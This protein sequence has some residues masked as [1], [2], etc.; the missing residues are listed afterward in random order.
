MDTLLVKIS[1]YFEQKSVQYGV[2]LETI[3]VEGRENTSA[4]DVAK[5]LSARKGTSLFDYDVHLLREK[6][7]DLPW[8]R[9]AI[10]Q[11]RFPSTLYVRLTERRP[12]ALWHHQGKTHLIDDQGKEI[13]APELS[14]YRRLLKISGEDAPQYAPQIVTTLQPY[15]Y[16]K[17]RLT[18]AVLNGGRQWDLLFGK[19]LRIKLP[20]LEIHKALEYVADLM[21]KGYLDNPGIES[22]DVRLS[23]RTFFYLNQEEAKKHQVS[24]LQKKG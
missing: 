3:I 9:S 6:L 23:D 24:F 20:E 1:T 4:R 19:G 5:V 2:R 10:V 21:K 16:L 18:G 15:S 7:V 12:I 22:I 17:K 13:K 14:K 11:R 8:V